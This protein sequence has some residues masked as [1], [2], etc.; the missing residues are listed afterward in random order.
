[1]G[2]GALDTGP[3][4]GAGG[5]AAIGAEQ[6]AATTRAMVARRRRARRGVKGT[7]GIR[8]M[9]GLWGIRTTLER[10]VMVPPPTHEIE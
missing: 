8:A 7:S 10:I 3:R 9:C 2:S 5:T 6:A 1:V 4:D